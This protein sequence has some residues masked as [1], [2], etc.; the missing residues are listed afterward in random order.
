M[1]GSDPPQVIQKVSE[2]HAWFGQAHMKTNP[3]ESHSGRGIPSHWLSRCAEFKLYV[4]D[5]AFL[6]RPPVR[7]SNVYES[8]QSWI[9][10]LL[11]LAH[12][13]LQCLWKPFEAL[14][15]LEKLACVKPRTCELAGWYFQG[16]EWQWKAFASREMK[17]FQIPSLL[18][19][20]A[21]CHIISLCFII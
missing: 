4:R 16:A 20:I 19:C 21:F 8:A 10:S 6:N 17:M 13:C 9:I 3:W 5:L 2:A 1:E 12:K 14:K 7:P 15:V 18:L 11:A